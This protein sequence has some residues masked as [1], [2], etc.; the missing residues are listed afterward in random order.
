MEIGM[1]VHFDA[2]LEANL[3][4]CRENGISTCQLSV[5]PDKLSDATAEIIGKLCQAHG[6]RITSLV[7]GWSGPS[8]WNFTGGP[9]TLGIVPSAYRAVRVNELKDCARFAH[10]LGVT[11]ICT[12]LGFIPEN[13]SDTLYADFISALRHL[14]TYFK[15]LG[16]RLNMETGQETPVTLLRVINDINENNLGINF[17]PANF[18]MYGKANPIDALR[19][20]G[21]YVNGVHAK[22]GEY[23]TDGISLGVEK[24]LGKGHVNIELFIQT[25]FDI[26]YKGP[27]TI[28]R[29]ISGEQQK[30][31]VLTA[32]ALLLGIIKKVNQGSVGR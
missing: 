23:P 24:P 9:L 20:V 17:D 32:N 1:I 11:D 13:P 22:D 2:S 31:D 10:K 3:K 8:E 4:W 27:L 6:M 7:G 26:Q 18:L 28:E 16:V 25:L 15:V 14:V 5:S 30:Q 21:A 12:H 29:E 19:I